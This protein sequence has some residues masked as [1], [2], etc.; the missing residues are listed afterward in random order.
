MKRA[1]STLA[2]A[3]AIA[4]FGAG[5]LAQ[6]ASP[7]DAYYDLRAAVYAYERCTGTTFSAD[8][9]RA[10]ELQIEQI[11][12]TQL[13]GGTKLSTAQAAKAWISMRI[14]TQGCSSGPAA[15]ALDRFNSQLASAVM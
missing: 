14:A 15:A 1:L 13:G 8:Q 9:N 5:A 10:L 6:D 3:A 4:S 12:G 11:I 2:A 7:R